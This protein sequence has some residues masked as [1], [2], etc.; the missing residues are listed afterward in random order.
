LVHWWF[1][2]AVATNSGKNYYQWIKFSFV[3]L[4][5]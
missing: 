3:V 4:S 2:L 1:C 5:K